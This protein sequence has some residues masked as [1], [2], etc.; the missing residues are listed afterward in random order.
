MCVE[1]L[2]DDGESAGEHSVFERYRTVQTDDV[3]G[4]KLAVARE[5]HTRNGL[6][7]A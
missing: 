1:E 4:S 6:K 5:L 7:K 2:R 3:E